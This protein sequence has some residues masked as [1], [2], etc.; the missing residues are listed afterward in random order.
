MLFCLMAFSMRKTGHVC[1]QQITGPLIILPLS[2]DGV[3]KK[4]QNETK[5]GSDFMKQVIS[6]HFLFWINCYSR[7]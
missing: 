3:T 6:Y 1:K 5:H 7:I 2:L 4:K